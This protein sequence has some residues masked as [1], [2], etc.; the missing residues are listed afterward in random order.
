MKK[1]GAAVNTTTP[2]SK[3]FA[4]KIA[5]R[6]AAIVRTVMNSRLTAPSMKKLTLSTSCVVRPI[7]SPDPAAS[8]VPRGREVTA[9]TTRS[10]STARIFCEKT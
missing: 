5:T 9:L 1:I 2:P 3:G 4:T 7:M 10:R 8:T 6:V